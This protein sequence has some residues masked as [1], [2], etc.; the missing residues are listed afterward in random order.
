LGIRIFGI[1]KSI[2]GDKKF[3]PSLMGLLGLGPEPGSR[4]L[5]DGEKSFFPL[6]MG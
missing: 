3:C 6:S 5:I 2:E 1:Y 4:K